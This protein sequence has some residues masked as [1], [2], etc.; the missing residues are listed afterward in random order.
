MYEGPT[1][2]QMDSAANHAGFVRST[3]RMFGAP[4]MPQPSVT[5]SW[6]RQETSTWPLQ[7]GSQSWGKVGWH[8]QQL[9]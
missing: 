8:E 7:R 1:G 9:S 3:L 6:Q 4:K 5:A 2:S